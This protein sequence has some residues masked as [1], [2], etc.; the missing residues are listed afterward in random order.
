MNRRKKRISF[1]ILCAY[2][3][4][5]LSIPAEA[6]PGIS[7]QS[8]AVIDVESGRILYQKQG[9][10]KMRVASLT[11]I[12]TAIVAIEEGRL[13]DMVA[14]PDQAIGTEGS[15]IYL[16]HGEKLTLEHLLYGL[17]LRSGNDAAVSIAHHIGGSLEG[18]ARLMNEKAEYLGLTQTHFTNPHGLDDSNNH[19]STAVDMAKISAYAL[20]NEDFKRIVS[21]KVI[22]IPQ[23]GEKWDRKL[24]NKNKMLHLYEGADGVKTGYTK[25]AKRCLV[26]SATRDGRQLAVV[27]LNAPSDWSDHARLL[28]YGFKQFERVE[29]VGLKENVDASKGLYSINAFYY[30]LASGER[31]NVRRQIVMEEG[32]KELLPGGVA[33]YLHIY[34]RDQQIGRIGLVYEGD[35]STLG[36]GGKESGWSFLSIFKSLIWGGL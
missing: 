9:Y 13:S 32:Y 27:T 29:L 33:G 28:D 17:M 15:S 21:T 14:V 23:H 4:S 35:K 10:E 5:L 25:L 31:Q 11:K 22:N 19:Y 30:P 12:M 8:A 16:R 26:S 3:I 36:P 1:I 18:F 6:A 24:I 34:L 20:Q 7:A 2:L